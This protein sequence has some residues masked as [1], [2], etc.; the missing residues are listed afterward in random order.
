[1]R[2]GY[3][4]TKV[5]SRTHAEVWQEAGKI[6]IK[7]VK[8]SNGTFVNG[9]RLSS[10]GLESEPYEL[11]SDDHVEFGIDIVGDDNKTVVH[12]KVSSKAFCIFNQG[13]VEQSLR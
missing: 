13:D 1:E 10:E 6:F 7:D 4:D 12:H 5:L 9:E 8:S 2:N 3:F 11:K